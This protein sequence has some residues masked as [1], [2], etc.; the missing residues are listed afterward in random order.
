MVPV[1]FSSSAL[2]SSAV[3]ITY[4]SFANSYPFTISS[5]GT[6][7]SLSLGQMYCC[8]TRDPHFLWSM[9]KETLAFDSADEKICTGT[10]T[11]PKEIVAVAIFRAGMRVIQTGS[12][13]DGR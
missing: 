1:P 13:E 9:L 8:F 6:T 11:R 3:R 10:D 5:R 12:F 4:W 7:S 2:I